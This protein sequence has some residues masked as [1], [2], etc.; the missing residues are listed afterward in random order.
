[1]YGDA[2][3]ISLIVA[4]PIAVAVAISDLRTM[5]IPNW[6][7]G[8]A[9]VIFLA[10]VFALLPLEAALWRVAGA[11]LVFVACVALFFMGAMGGGDAKAAPGFALLVAPNDAAVVLLLL[12]IVALVGVV[13][14]AL[15]RRTALGRGSWKVWSEVGRF[16]YGLALASTIL[17]YLALAAFL[18]P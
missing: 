10:L 2:A 15:L 6:L 7:T 16:P 4:T 11:G 14:I 1:M 5:E 3:L 8:G 17:I 13:V 12:S 18:I 9:A